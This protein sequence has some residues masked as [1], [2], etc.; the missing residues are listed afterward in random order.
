MNRTGVKKKVNLSKKKL[1]NSAMELFAAHGFEATTTRAI[2]K[3]AGVNLSLIP[4]YFGNKDGLYLSIIESVTKYGN[5]FLKDEITKVNYLAFMNREEK[6][7]LYR[8]MLKK[9]A[10]FIYSEKVPYNF[11]L[12]LLK[13][14]TIANSKFSKRY[15]ERMRIV[16][17][18][19]VNLLAQITG[20]NTNE[21]LL[22]V[23]IFAIVGQIISLKLTSEMLLNYLETDKLSPVQMGL[24]KSSIDS[25]INQHIDKIQAI[26]SYEDIKSTITT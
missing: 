19:M 1:L 5:A 14:Q 21:K 17:R 13:E 16:Y 20:I 8:T 2:C 18:S 15:L 9:Y 23:E 25:F 10:D 22:Y 26:H 4:Y 7:E 6:I 3:N 12:L 24:V 11:I